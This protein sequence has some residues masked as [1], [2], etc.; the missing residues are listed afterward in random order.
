MGQDLVKDP[1]EDH[2]SGKHVYQFLQ[3][4][5]KTFKFGI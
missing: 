3:N 5:G 2:P 1:G 4:P